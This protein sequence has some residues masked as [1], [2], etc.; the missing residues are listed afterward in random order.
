MRGRAVTGCG[1]AGGTLLALML[2]FGVLALPHQREMLTP[3]AGLRAPVELPV[4]VLLLAL[5]PRALRTPVCTLMAVLLTLLTLFKLADMVALVAYWRIF[6]PVADWRLLMPAWDFLSGSLGRGPALALLVGAAVVLLLLA[7]LLQ[8]ALLRIA[9]RARAALQSHAGRRGWQGGAVLYAVWLAGTL[10]LGQ[11]A[12]NQQP[13]APAHS[14]RLLL[15]HVQQSW[16]N[17]HELAELRR[18]VARHPDIDVPTA[19]LFSQLA[20]KDIVI[21]FLESYGRSALEDPRYAPQLEQRLRT[22]EGELER[23]GFRTRSAWVHSPTVGGQS[24]LAHTT[25]QTG[26]WIDSQRRYNWVIG[27]QR[28][29]LA[30][31]FG[32]AGWR[33]V[34]VSPAI[35]SDW[36]AGRWFGFQ[37]TLDARN[38]GYRGRPYNWITMPD[39]YTYSAFQRLELGRDDRPPLMAMISTVSSHAPWVPVPPM[40]GWEQVKEGRILSRWADANDPPSVVWQDSD[41]VRH[42]YRKAI[43]YSLQA[44]GSFVA[45]YGDDDLVVI[46]LGDHQPASIIT[47][48]HASREVPVHL[49]TR[50]REVLQAFGRWGWTRGMIPGETSATW[51]MDEFRQRL[52]KGF[53]GSSAAPAS[54]S[55]ADG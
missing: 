23:S 44:L 20:G 6:D 47:G 53:S 51:G 28:V 46:A 50:D 54:E 42:Q 45:Y 25:L 1:R 35:T 40:V 11:P 18:E 30:R 31:L 26:L 55:P 34:D 4:I 22:I 36:P 12:P 5:T 7:W 32:R 38:L 14:S 33:T 19:R 37:R 49:M 43:D 3:L 2:I 41:R 13:A 21:V 16:R 27:S 48:N 10:A 24:W 29:P 15:A 52:I 9:R 17:L 8:R 39:Q